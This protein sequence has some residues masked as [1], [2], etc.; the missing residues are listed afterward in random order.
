MRTPGKQLTTLFDVGETIKVDK[1]NGKTSHH[2]LNKRYLI[3]S[4]TAGIFLEADILDIVKRVL[5]L[6]MASDNMKKSFSINFQA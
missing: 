3:G 6:P 4:G 5:N 1:V 2:C